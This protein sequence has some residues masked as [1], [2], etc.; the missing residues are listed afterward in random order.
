MAQEE[1]ADLLSILPPAQAAS[2]ERMLVWLGSTG[3]AP[4]DLEE[5][6]SPRWQSQSMARYAVDMNSLFAR[7]CRIEDIAADG[8]VEARCLLRDRKGRQQELLLTFESEGSGRILRFCVRPVLREDVQIR[9]PDTGD[10]AAMRRLERSAPVQREDGTEVIIDHNGRQFERARVVSD[11][12]WLAAFQ[13]DRMVAVQGVTLATAPI[14]GVMCRIAYNHYSRSDPETR[15]GGNLIY[16]VSTLYRDIYPA[17]D[18]FLSLVDVQNTAGL[19]LSFGKPWPVRVRRLFLPVASLAGRSA[20]SPSLR[21]FDAAH[22]AA[23]LNA[24]H[25]GMNLWVP[26]TPDFLVERQRRAPAIYGPGCWRLTDQAALALWPSGERRVYRKEGSE[27]AR[28][29]ALALD[30]GFTGESGREQLIG[31]LCE[32]ARELSVQGISHIAIF[33]SDCHPSTEWLAELAEA[34]DTYA[35]CA[36]SLNRPAQPQGPVYIDHIVF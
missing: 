10:I 27:T 32:A 6:I 19:R 30:Y 18:Q 33:V 5:V 23:L 34:A 29:L 25:E 2:V 15:H 9:R 35:V 24:T 28:T 12:R 20:T 7:E 13:S 22:L 4:A 17:I 8:N 3:T 11:H 21:A 16:L 26:R 14:G 31:L 36:P 1:L